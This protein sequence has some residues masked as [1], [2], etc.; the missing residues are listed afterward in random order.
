ML[1]AP[2]QPDHVQVVVRYQPASE[3]A[4][5]GGDWYDAFLQPDGSTMLVIGDVVGHDLEAAAV[6]AQLRSML[7]AI[8]VVTRD[9]PAEVLAHLDAAARTLRITTMASVVVARL[10]QT[11]QEEELGVTRVRWSAAGHPP[12]MVVNEWGEV[13]QLV[14]DSPGW[15][16][17]LAPEHP[18]VDSE[19]V[20]E[21]GSTLLLYTDGL[22]EQR[23]RTI[24]D[25]LAALEHALSQHAR[26]DL[27]TLC[28]R[29]L[30]D[31]P[32][33]PGDDDIAMLAARLHRQDRP[34]PAEAGPTR[35]PPD[36]PDAENGDP[37]V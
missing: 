27:D 13:A 21:R 14:S 34:R 11:E 9:S 1:T 2:V 31:L 7:R 37:S 33:G 17:G 22:I 16:L 15:L 36:V 3:G 30:T 26:R 28:D 24:G 8:A 35:V 32:A 19:V 4:Q 23:G 29:L 5:V 20:L 12:P 25:G 10:E 6:M 18:R